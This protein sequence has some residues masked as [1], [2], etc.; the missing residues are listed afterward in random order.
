MKKKLKMKDNNFQPVHYKPYC[1]RDHN[2][3]Y[4]DLLRLILKKG[5]KK[6]PIHATLTENKGSGH[7]YALEL[8]GK[9][10]SYDLSNGVPILPIRDLER[11]YKGAIGEIV[12][13]INGAH[14]LEELKKFG[15]PKVFWERW[16]TKEKCAVWNLE[17]GDLGP[18]SYG[19]ILTA[20][21]MGNGE[22]FNQLDAMINQ[23]KRAASARTHLITTW[24]PPLALGDATQKS[25]R[26][27]VVAPCHG[28]MVQFNVFEDQMDMILYQRSADVPVGLVLNLAE[29]VAFGMMVSYLTKIPLGE[30][31][32]YLPNPQIYDIQREKVNELLE[33]ESRPFPS[34]YLRPKRIIKSIYDFRKEDFELENYT[35]H[36]RMDIPTPI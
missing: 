7:S 35:P 11:S 32:H 19:T 1:D 14:T 13:F 16:V 29:W 18:G 23:M 10:L 3:Q 20:M 26:Q 34:L 22:T 5:K 25:P 36:P 33:R 30:Y 2:T 28:N 8:S 17:E 21:P 15:C 24:Y 12:A 9:M 4:E 31:I 6:K 27:V